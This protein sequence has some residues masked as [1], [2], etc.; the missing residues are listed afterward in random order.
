MGRSSRPESSAQVSA[1]NLYPSRASGQYLLL[2]ADRYSR[3]Y[4]SKVVLPHTF[5]D[6]LLD[7]L[8]YPLPEPRLLAVV[9]YGCLSSCVVAQAHYLL[10]GNTSL[11]SR[12]L[13]S[14][15]CDMVDTCLYLCLLIVRYH[16]LNSRLGLSLLMT[17]YP[18]RVTVVHCYTIKI[19]IKECLCLRYS[20]TKLRVVY[21]DSK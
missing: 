8:S 20:E 3:R 5:R 6:E 17:A 16:Y 12:C 4:L 14:T 18:R 7:T 13:L 1:P 2:L 9:P 10:S 21:R 19:S 15:C 11:Y